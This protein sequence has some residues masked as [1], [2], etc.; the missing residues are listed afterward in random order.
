MGCSRPR[1]LSPRGASM[2]RWTITPTVRGK[3]HSMIS[4]LLPAGTG[5]VVSNYSLTLNGSGP[6]GAGALYNIVGG[7][8]TWS[9]PIV[10]AT[11][12]SVGVALPTTTL[13]TAPNSSLTL[14]DVESLSVEAHSVV[15]TQP[16]LNLVGPGTL[17]FPSAPITPPR[18]SSPRE[19]YSPALGPRLSRAG[20]FR[21]MPIRMSPPQPASVPSSSTAAP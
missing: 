19:T 15:P 7:N 1:T 20:T 3:W 12:S 10:L 17:I 14:T 8:N 16:I 6:T 9:G 21:S 5:L 2:C 11:T 13:P 4:A 18:R